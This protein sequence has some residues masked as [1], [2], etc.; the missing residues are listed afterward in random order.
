MPVSEFDIIREY[1]SDKGLSRKDVTRGIGDDGAVLQVPS[2]MELVVSLDTLVAGVHFSNDTL[3]DAIAYKSL[4]VSLS[5]LAAM[6]AAPAW[7]TL[8]ITLPGIDKLWLEQFSEG[9]FTVADQYG[10]QLIGGDT[11]RGPLAV[12]VQAHGFVPSG[13]ACYRSSARVGDDIY[14]TGTLGDAG[15]ALLALNGDFRPEDEHGRYLCERLERPQP[16]VAV[17]L[18][19]RHLIHSMIDVS[20]GLVADLG[21]ILTASGVGARLHV[22]NI[23]LS[24]PFISARATLGEE[25]CLNLALSAG[26]DYELCFTASPDDR[27]RIQQLLSTDDCHVTLIGVIE[28]GS[29]LVCVRN[30]GQSYKPA[31]QGYDH[32]LESQGDP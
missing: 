21:H 11:T 12:T 15:L 3:P 20:D 31:M 8:G 6:G 14:V 2:G 22:D 19:L 26:D 24:E 16:R 1:F 30:S 10:V 17:A 18:A 5:D 13:G 32:F 28:P 25:Q 7:A 27:G 4:A 9:L 29:E 23:P